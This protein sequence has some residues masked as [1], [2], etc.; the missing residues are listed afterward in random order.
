MHRVKENL[1]HAD[2][3]GSVLS[4]IETRLTEYEYSYK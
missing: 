4:L 2:V 3:S 1:M